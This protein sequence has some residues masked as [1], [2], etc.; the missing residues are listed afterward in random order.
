MIR[1]FKEVIAMIIEAIPLYEGISSTTLIAFIQDPI[2]DNIRLDN[3]PAVIISPGGAFLGIT[4]KEAEPVALRFVTS[5]YQAFVLNYSIGGMA[6][7]PQPFIDA[8]KAV[9]MVRENAGKWGINPDQISLCGFS[10]GGYVSAFLGSIWH[11][12]YLSDALNVQNFLLKP[13]ALILG[14][15]L[16][17]MH[18]LRE[19]N[20]EAPEKKIM[21]EMVFSAAYGTSH[22]DTES[23]QRWDI[24]GRITSSMPP[25]FLWVTQEDEYVDMEGAVDFMRALDRHRIPCE[26]HAFQKGIHGMSLGDQPLGYSDKRVKE[27]GNA[28]KW[29]DL[30]LSWLKYLQSI[31]PM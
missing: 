30:A 7:F 4:E 16:L 1:F 13:N 28:P 25:T 29:M 5:G 8:A 19:K 6:L 18:R 9:L 12:K 10:T 23:M 31:G 3:K 27:F 24:E 11:E 22:P 2:L 21:M 15:P 20:L 17:D 14:Y 26:F